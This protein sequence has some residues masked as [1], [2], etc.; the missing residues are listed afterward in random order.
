MDRVNDEAAAPPPLP[1]PWLWAAPGIVLTAVAA[2]CGCYELT[3]LS[4]ADLSKFELLQ[5]HLSAALMQQ[6]QAQLQPAEWVAG[7]LA[8]SLLSWLFPRLLI[9]RSGL[10]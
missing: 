4:P 10:L 3:R 9:G 1:F 6:L 2:S 5:P 8:V 7:A